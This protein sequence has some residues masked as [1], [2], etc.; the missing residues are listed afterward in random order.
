M[1]KAE[2]SARKKKDPN[3]PKRALAAY[4]FFAK[5]NRSIIKEENADIS[6]G[7][8]GRML[9][10]RWAD[11]DADTKKKYQDMAAKDKVRYDKQM[12]EYNA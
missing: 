1:P 6:F 2:S 3:A 5:E 10:Q 9:G 8:I 11:A 12:S 7:D 4:M